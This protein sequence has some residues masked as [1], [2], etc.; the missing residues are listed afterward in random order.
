MSESRSTPPLCSLL[1]PLLTTTIVPDV[2]A[3]ADVALR[4]ADADV[5]CR[6]KLTAV[7]PLPA[8][9]PLFRKFFGESVSTKKE[10]SNN[11]KRSCKL[12]LP[13]IGLSVYETYGKSESL[14]TLIGGE[15]G[16][17]ESSG[18]GLLSTS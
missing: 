11:R 8:F 3:A 7:R 4:P 10:N 18:G 14:Q 13:P 5:D 1:L 16:L 17:D 6:L 9:C 2:V 15:V 12:N